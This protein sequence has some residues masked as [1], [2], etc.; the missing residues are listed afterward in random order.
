SIDP[1]QLNQGK[2]LLGTWGGDND[3]DLHFPRYCRLIAGGRLNLQPLVERTYSLAQIND[4]LDDLESQRCAR[5]LI[6]M[7]AD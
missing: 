6:D 3:P 5:P 7:S 4:A 2:R 1:Q